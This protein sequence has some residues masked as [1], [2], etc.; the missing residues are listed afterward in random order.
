MGLTTK[1]DP[2]KR[3][4]PGDTNT[5]PDAFVRDFGGLPAG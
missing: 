4:P 2:V 3:R 1:E 5:V